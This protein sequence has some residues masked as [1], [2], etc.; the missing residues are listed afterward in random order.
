MGIGLKTDLNLL[1]VLL[2]VHDA[3]NVTAAALRLKMSQP[4]VSAALARLRRSLDDPLFVRQG[5]RMEAT[6]RV[7]AMIE[8]T[9]EALEIIDRDVL[10]SPL[11]QPGSAVGELTFCLS[12]IG[13]VTFFPRIY[14]HMRE[15]APRLKLKA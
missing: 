11:F 6:S 1:R 8:K 12:E 7:R 14:L 13:E 4:A 5:T 9:R 2:A 3:G 10:S 15:V